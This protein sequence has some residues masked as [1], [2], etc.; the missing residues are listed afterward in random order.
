M[1]VKAVP[2]GWHTVTPRLFVMDAARLVDFLKH[3]FGATGNFRK[4][5]PSEIHIGDSILLVAEAGVRDAMPAFLYL[6]LDDA[7]TAY[8]RAL[9][10]GA[11]VIEEPQDMF[12]GDRRA[13]V[14]DPF[15]NI[16]QIATHKE[17]LTLEEIQRRA[18]AASVNNTSEKSC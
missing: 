15:G 8:R 4:D 10:A 16:W 5:G 6:Y 14:R 9:E 18:V 7:D 11:I 3:A 13:T 2:E 12:Y 17:D 1:T